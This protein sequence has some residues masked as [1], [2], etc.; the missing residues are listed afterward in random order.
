MITRENEKVCFSYRKEHMKG[1]KQT[2]RICVLH[3]IFR[4][5]F[6]FLFTLRE[7]CTLRRIKLRRDAAMFFGESS[8]VLKR[9]MTFIIFV[10]IAIARTA[11]KMHFIAILNSTD[12]AINHW[13]RLRTLRHYGKVNGL[14]QS[15]YR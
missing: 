5:Y 10:E 7:F 1:K 15:H 8:K 2:V 13:Y 4:Y 11:R 12:S 9:T 3:I 6:S 14:W